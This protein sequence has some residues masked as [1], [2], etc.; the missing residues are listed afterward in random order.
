MGFVNAFK[1]VIKRVIANIVTAIHRLSSQDVVVSQDGE[2]II[3]EPAIKGFGDKL[4]A[5]VLASASLFF[6]MSPLQGES[7][8]KIGDQLIR[9]AA[10]LWDGTD[11]EVVS[12]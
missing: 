11:P 8:M 1:A 2:I 12:A 9:M 3:R 10:V 4:S 7:A 5:L 6:L